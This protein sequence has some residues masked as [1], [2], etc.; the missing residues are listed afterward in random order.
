MAA[1]GYCSNGV[2]LEFGHR[3]ARN[4]QTDSPGH[5]DRSASVH[6]KQPHYYINV[7]IHIVDP[8]GY[9]K[10]RKDPGQ[11]CRNQIT[12]ERGA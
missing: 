8:S 3:S 1:G 12:G 11:C 4:Q 9:N 2:M 10:V 6:F 5:W 7:Q